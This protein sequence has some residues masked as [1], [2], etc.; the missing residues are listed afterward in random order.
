MRIPF[1]TCTLSKT[2]LKTY[3]QQLE[4][5]ADKINFIPTAHIY[6]IENSQKEVTRRKTRRKR[7]KQHPPHPTP[8]TWSF[9]P[10]APIPLQPVFSQVKVSIA[11]F[12]ILLYQ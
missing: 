6:I 5:A 7:N 11:Y 3:I 12:V 1:V 10:T 4:L 2:L 9:E 8:P